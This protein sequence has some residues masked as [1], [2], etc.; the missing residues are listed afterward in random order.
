[1]LGL[2]GVVKAVAGKSL[3]R[4][5]ALLQ[6][7]VGLVLHLQQVLLLQLEAASEG[8]D[9]ALGLDIPAWRENLDILLDDLRLQKQLD[10]ALRFGICGPV[11]E[12]M[13]GAEAKE[14]VGMRR[15]VGFVEESLGGLE[16]VYRGVGGNLEGV[17]GVLGVLEGVV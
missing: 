1:M 15:F 7:D 11:G 13:G 14:R 5:S 9:W 2:M 12:G 16:V 10:E 8:P 4:K 3:V 17:L 6:R